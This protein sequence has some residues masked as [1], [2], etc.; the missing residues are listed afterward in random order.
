MPSYLPRH[1]FLSSEP[2]DPT[3]RRRVIA[4]RIGL[5]V[6]MVGA[7]LFIAS[8]FANSKPKASPAAAV[9]THRGRAALHSPTTAKPGRGSGG[10]GTGHATTSTSAPGHG[11]QGGG[12]KGGR[13]KVT[14]GPGGVK[15]PSSP[16]GG[17]AVTT[18]GATSSS[19]AYAL[20][21][22]AGFGPLLRQVWVAAD[23][24][25][26]GLTAGDVQSTYPG[27]VYYASQPALGDYW[28][29]S[30][31]LPTMGAQDQGGSIAGRAVLD[32][33]NR[34]G[35]FFKARGQAWA[36]LGGFPSTGCPDDVPAP[37]LQAWG[38]CT[39]GS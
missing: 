38:I 8:V 31:F 14:S 22:P 33:F 17:T 34:G 3:G 19:P 2:E 5:G 15:A 7:A 10:A 21:T 11:H 32:Q 29:L 12:A 25:G 16:G 9:T 13:A 28:S 18:S 27:S 35:V 30:R 24:G 23:P 6:V 20:V 1:R 37:V 26:V 36:Y 39:V 4:V